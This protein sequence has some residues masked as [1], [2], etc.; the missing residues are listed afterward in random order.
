MHKERNKDRKSIHI[1]S[2]KIFSTHMKL[3]L[4]LFSYCVFVD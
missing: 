1:A 4:Y 2:S 3:V